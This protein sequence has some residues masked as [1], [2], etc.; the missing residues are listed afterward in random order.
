[1][2]EE[3]KR[4]RKEIAS[5]RYVWELKLK[6]AISTGK[7]G[8]ETVCTTIIICQNERDNELL[9]KLRGTSIKRKCVYAAIDQNYNLF[10]IYQ[11]CV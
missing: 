2:S 4:R 6:G 11:T 5:H 1:M 8:S 7:F 10:W 3:K 9:G